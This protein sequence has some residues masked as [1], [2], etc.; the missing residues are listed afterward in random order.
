MV[1]KVP[2]LSLSSAVKLL[3]WLLLSMLLL[4]LLL[5]VVVV[6][7]LL[8]LIGTKDGSRDGS[9]GST[10]GVSSRPI[11]TTYVCRSYRKSR[12]QVRDPIKP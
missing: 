6:V 8:L 12:M 2:P 4:L 7:L 1:N 3:L 5:V 9:M 11:H 10:G